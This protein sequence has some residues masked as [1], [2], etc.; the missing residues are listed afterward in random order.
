MKKLY[1]NY[2][3]RLFLFI[4]SMVYFF[5]NNS[6][7]NRVL[8]FALLLSVGLIGLYL[9]FKIDRN[10]TEELTSAKQCFRRFK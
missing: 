6:D 2:L 4:A 3:P 8:P 10:R 7:E 1:L 5:F 9:L